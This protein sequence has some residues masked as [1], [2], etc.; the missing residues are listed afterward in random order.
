MRVVQNAGELEEG[1][2]RASSEALAAFGDGSIFIE[3][4]VYK[5]RHIEVQILGDGTG[6]VVHLYDRLVLVRIHSTLLSLLLVLACALLP[7]P[8]A[9]TA[10]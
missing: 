9:C 6:N 8:L 5:P 1:Y 10:A 2:N 7:L 4:Y 3:R